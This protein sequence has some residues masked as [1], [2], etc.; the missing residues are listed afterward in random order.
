[1]HAQ[2][3]VLRSLDAGWHRGKAMKVLEILWPLRPRRSLERIRAALAN[4]LGRCAERARDYDVALCAYGR[5][6]RAPGRERRARLLRRLGDEGGATTLLDAIERHPLNA[7]ERYFAERFRQTARRAPRIPQRVVRLDEPPQVG[8]E[9][10]ALALL[11]RDGGTGAHLENLVSL[12][13]LGLACW[14]VVFAPV[15]AAFVNPYQSGPLD[16]YW[17]DFRRP[18]EALINE[19]FATLAEPGAFARAVR[20]TAFAKRGINNALVDW[21]ALDARFI[22]TATTAVPGDV[23]LKIFDHMLDDLEQTR[24]GFPDLTLCFGRDAFQF[25]EVK[26][27]GDQLRREQRLWFEFFATAGIPA[28]VL[29]VEW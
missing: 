16:L 7:G 22:D 2:R 23:W 3:E 14:D 27:P 19:R 10:S 13:M 15:E 11:T 12:G 24:T 25:V 8:V 1:L 9:T 29:R 20:S 28:S 17:S 18:R 21:H 5:A 4:R 26:G 6:T